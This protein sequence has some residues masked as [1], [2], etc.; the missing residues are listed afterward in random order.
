MFYNGK[1]ISFIG[2]V[3]TILLEKNKIISAKP[4]GIL[5]YDNS[6]IKP[7]VG[8]NVVV[9][10][11]FGSYLISEIKERK[12]LLIRPNVA[13]IDELLII[14]SIIQPDINLYL[15]DKFLAHYESRVNNVSIYFS[16]LDLLSDDKRQEIESI[17][18]MYK[19][20]GYSIYCSNNNEDI[21]KIKY[22][23]GHKTMCLA[24]NS[25]VGKSTLLNK[26]NPELGLKTQ[27]I[28]LALN[29]GKHTTTNNQMIIY[30]KGMFI[31]TPG[32]SSID[33]F[34]TPQELAN[35]F[36]DFHKHSPL[37]KFSNC[38]HINEPN[39][40][41]KELVN[42]SKISMSRYKNYLRMQE[43]IKFKKSN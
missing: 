8:D 42:A 32:F 20:N 40:K 24:G 11:N 33:I 26:I 2:G 18:K 21:E 9:E 3:A 1:I 43:E 17:I 28:S 19:E 27:K 38:L 10:E 41:I 7:V 36:H 16:K 39:C 5:R 35:S 22:N 23:L 31:D 14:Q 6:S 13:N 15:L 4:K 29:R 25:G 30:E 34:L 37:C 12:N